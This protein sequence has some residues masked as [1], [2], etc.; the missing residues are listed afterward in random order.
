MKTR[1]RLLLTVMVALCLLVAVPVVLL[2]GA[3]FLVK[4]ATTTYRLEWVG[5]DGEV[6]YQAHSVGRDDKGD[7]VKVELSDYWTKGS[8]SYEIKIYTFGQMHLQNDSVMVSVAR[9]GHDVYEAVVGLRKC[10]HS[11]RNRYDVVLPLEC[12]PSKEGETLTMKF[13]FCADAAPSDWRSV[14]LVFKAK[15]R[16]HYINIFADIT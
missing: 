13:S 1:S 9:E 7:S 4:Y 6:W 2:E 3:Y 12:V 5:S 14:N 11:D 10:L 15:S 8:A 16:R